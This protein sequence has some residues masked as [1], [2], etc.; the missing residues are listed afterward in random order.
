MSIRRIGAFSIAIVLLIGSGAFAQGNAAI[1]QL[2]QTSIGLGSTIHLLQGHQAADA[3]Q[4]LAVANGQSADRPCGAYANQGLLANLAEI[5]HASGDCA[6]VG[7]LQ[8]LSIVGSQAQLIGDAC[9]PKTE[10]QTI[11]LLADQG[12][13]KSEGPGEGSGLHQI[14]FRADQGA[15][16]AAGGLQQSAAIL[17]LQ[18]SS[19]AGSACA[20]G[21]VNSAMSVSTIQSH[22]NP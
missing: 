9:G 15:G 20:T 10:G 16:N 18:N 19:L 13:V 4:N 12:I 8:G 14:V 22:L 5:G 21:A 2:Q 1:N 17:G 11:N 3:I 7:V 6:L